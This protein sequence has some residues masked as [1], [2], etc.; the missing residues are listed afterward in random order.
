VSP[1]PLPKLPPVFG[2][3]DADYRPA[4]RS[5]LDILTDDHR[6]ITRLLDRLGRARPPAVAVDVLV[7]TMSRHLCSEEQYLYP[8]VRA[9]LPGG[10][11]LADRELLEHAMLRRGLDRLSVVTPEY[12]GFRALVE[13]IAEQAGRH[14]RQAV[15][16]IFPALRRSC[17]ESELIRL[18][19][20]V[21]IAQESAPTRAHPSAP[22]RPPANK[23]V[24][25]AV[26]VL[27]YVRDGLTGRSTWP[28]AYN[29]RDW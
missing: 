12:A 26:G 28:D 19:N 13:E 16:E 10:E 24:N 3:D 1:A 7:A 29:H 4:G 20:R 23:V 11:E 27:D 18:G 21:T 22:L 6:M 15:E 2:I 17:P 8:T 9:V 14:A 5:M 25:A